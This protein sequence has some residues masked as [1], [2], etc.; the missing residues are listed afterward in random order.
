VKDAFANKEREKLQQISQGRWDTLRKEN[1]Y[2]KVMHF[3]L[4]D[5]QSFLRMHDVPVFGDN[6]AQKRPMVA[7]V[8]KE[9][10]P[11]DGFEE[12]VYGFLYRVFL[13]VFH[14][15]NYIGTLE[16]GS[17]PKQILE[18]MLYYNNISGAL[19]L[20]KNDSTKARD[21]FSLGKYHLVF[22]NF[23]EEDSVVEILK[24]Y[25]F[26]THAHKEVDG[27]VYVLYTFDMSDFNGVSTAKVV[28]INDITET[29]ALYNERLQSLFV[30][31]FSLLFI[32]LLVVNVGFKKIIAILDK[33]N[34]DLKTN[35]KFLQSILDNSAH[36]IIATDRNGM[37]TMFN[38]Q[39]QKLLQY[40]AEEVIGK[41]NIEIFYHKE[42][43]EKKSIELFKKIKKDFMADFSVCVEKTKQN[44]ENRDE[45]RFLDKYN[46]PYDVQVNVTTLSYNG[47]M[48]SG[49]NFIIEDITAQKLAN[50][51]IKDYVKLIDRNIITSTTDLD[52]KIIHI[53]DAFCHVSG[54]EKEELLGNRFEKIRHPDIEKELFKNMWKT[55]LNDNIFIAELKSLK[56][57]GGFFWVATTIYPIYD[58]VK[59]KIG[60]TSIGRD[61]TD[62]KLLEELAITDGL[63]DI[64]NRRHF[65]NLFTQIITQSKRKNELLSFIIIDVDYF[66]LYNDTYGHQKGDEALKKVAL[67]LKNSLKRADDYCFRLGGEEFGVVFKPKDKKEALDMAESI[68]KK[69]S[70]LKIPHE[71]SLVDKYLSISMGMITKYAKEIKNDDEIYKAAD[72]LLY[73]AKEEGRNRVVSN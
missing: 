52:G 16:F 39:A 14:N 32:L 23:E 53:S 44:I 33:T 35:E 37:I 7:K 70:S 63:T 73:Q 15:E 12:G 34:K 45:W 57:D 65:N 43:L 30:F 29:V 24:D 8:N 38:N 19:F 20:N 61:I 69:L 2:L 48:M 66:K 55:L 26:L 1:Q 62:K 56:K 67:A 46:H 47:D 51:K 60:Y 50:K 10:K 4:A 58:S 13:P 27:H 59:N 49:Y 41:K 11:L 21:G 22:D 28:F 5:G 31:L 17:E 25:D 36:A 3:I 40:S 71:T 54:Y 72:D 68:R 6:I 64:Y 18:E 9:Q 42:D